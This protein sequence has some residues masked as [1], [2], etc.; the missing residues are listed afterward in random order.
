G[1]VELP[2]PRP[3]EVTRAQRRVVRPPAVFPKSEGPHRPVLVALHLGGHPR[4]RQEVGVEDHQARE[5]RGHAGAVEVLVEVVAGR[6]VL[7]PAAAP[8]P[9]GLLLGEL[10]AGG[11]PRRLRGLGLGGEAEPAEG[12][13]R[14]DDLEEAAPAHADRREAGGEEIQLGIRERPRRNP[15]E[16][17][18]CD[19]RGYFSLGSSASRTPSPKKVNESM[20]TAMQIAGNTQRCQYERRNCWFSPTICP[21][22]GVGGLIPTP[23][24]DSAASVKIASG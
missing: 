1:R 7:P 18:S 10:L 24:K 12:G 23:M 15:H 13:H 11:G 22:E 16:Q 3:L 6:I 2:L 21:H 9:E 14:A 20:V 8:E 17:S 4:N 5:E 19:L